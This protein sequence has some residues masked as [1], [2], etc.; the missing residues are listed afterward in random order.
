MSK[1]LIAGSEEQK[2]FVHSHLNCSLAK[3]GSQC[4]VFR[5]RVDS[6]TRSA[7]IGDAPSHCSIDS[8][9]LLKWSDEVFLCQ[10]DH[11]HMKKHGDTALVILGRQDLGSV[12]LAVVDEVHH[13]RDCEV[14]VIGQVDCVGVH[15][16]SE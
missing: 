12:M 8:G 9:V 13:C 11:A 10:T 5:A 6:V 16:T 15:R 7:K 1:I 4:N 14:A 3:S 2:G